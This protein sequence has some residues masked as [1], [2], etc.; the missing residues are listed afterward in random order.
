MHTKYTYIYTFILPTLHS[1][2]I[3]KFVDP[4]KTNRI[5]TNFNI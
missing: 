5:C 2:H 3:T 1:I 4:I